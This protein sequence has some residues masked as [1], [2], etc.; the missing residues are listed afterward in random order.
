MK[1]ESAILKF[2]GI[3][4]SNDW[5]VPISNLFISFRYIA[6]SIKM[7]RNYTSK[8]DAYFEIDKSTKKATCKLCDVI[9]RHNCD[10]MN[11]HMKRKHQINIPK[12]KNPSNRE[13]NN[14]ES[15]KKKLHID[16]DPI[17][18]QICDEVA[19]WGVSFR[20]DFMYWHLPFIWMVGANSV[21]LLTYD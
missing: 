20:W 10:G 18:D 8:Y 6:H 9:L 15:P 7:S 5:E 17:E 21:H 14:E 3:S 1:V 2:I 4:Q 11:K 19:E 16:V 12:R 13:E